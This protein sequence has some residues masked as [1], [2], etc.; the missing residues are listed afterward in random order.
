MRK[1]NRFI[2]SLILLAICISLMIAGM[3]LFKVLPN[4]VAGGY[5]NVKDSLVAT[6]V[7]FCFFF[8]FVTL[9]GSIGMLIY[10]FCEEE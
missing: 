7:G 2:L 4:S 9:C 10:G 5:E 3:L 6:G 8:A 1:R